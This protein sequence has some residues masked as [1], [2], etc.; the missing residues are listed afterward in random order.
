MVDAG[1][2][3]VVV[4]GG[5]LFVCESRAMEI[6]RLLLPSWRSP[7]QVERQLQHSLIY[8]LMKWITWTVCCEVLS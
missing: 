1:N 3:M 8:H 2:G 5:V 4:R 6:S 7:G